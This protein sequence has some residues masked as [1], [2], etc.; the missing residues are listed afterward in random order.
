[1]CVF[2]VFLVCNYGVLPAWGLLMISPSSDWTKRLVHSGLVPLVLGTVYLW[3]MVANPDALEGAGFTTLDGVMA[4]F[5]SPWVA[6]AGWVHYLIFDLFIG[7][8]EVRDAQRHG[9]RHAFVV[10]CLLLTLM[11]GPVGLGMYL[12]LRAGFGNGL[13]LAAVE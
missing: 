12:L 8:W 5:T 1:M 10:P 6:L 13:S 4:L 9:I 3:A 7:A 2:D 11:L